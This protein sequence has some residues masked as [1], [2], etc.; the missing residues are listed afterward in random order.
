[1]LIMYNLTTL[2]VIKKLKTSTTGLSLSEAN[3][4]L[5]KYGQN[6]LPQSSEKITKLGIFFDQWK[7]PLIIILV[8]AGVI[9]GFLGEYVDMTVISITVGVNIIIGFFQEY[10]ANEALKKLGKMIEY[11]AIVVRDGRQVQVAGVDIVP[12]DI[13]VLDAG[14]NIQAD[15]RIIEEVGLQV[16]ESV[17]TGESEPVKKQAKILKGEKSIG[18]RINMLFKG[19]SI[20]NGRARAVVVATG[21]DTEIGKIASLVKETKEDKTPL[22]KQL[23]SLGKKIGVV[24]LFISIAIF[25][26]GVFSKSEHHSL[27]EMF[28]TAVAVAVAAIPEGLVI[29]MTVILAIGMQH[30]LKRKA[31]VRK[32][33]A[34]ETLGSV[35]VI[36]TDKTGT[37]TEGKMRITRLVT[38]GDD[39]N[40]EELKLVNLKETDRHKN[41][42]LGLRIGIMCNDS[43]LTNPETNEKDWLFVGDTTDI[44]FVY[45]GMKIGLEKHT[46]DKVLTRVDEL[47]F[48]STNKFM[49][50]MHKI[51][52]E[53]LIYV[54]G[55]AEMLY[56]RCKFFEED[57]VVKKL[58]KEKLAWFKDQEEQMTMQGLRVLGLAYKKDN[59][60][61]KKI[62]KDKLNDLVLVGLVALS[63]PLRLDVKETINK[64]RLAG[65]RTV[66]ITGDHVRTAQSIAKELGIPAEDSQ[67]FDGQQ[68]EK[69]SSEELKEV[70]RNVY[71]FARVDPKHKIRIVQAFQANGEIVAMT[72]DGINDAPA[73][74]GADIGVA[75][76]SG[77]TVAKEISDMV[78]LDD[79]YNTIVSAV[80]EGRGIYQNI[81]KVIVYLLAGSFSEVFLIAGS[82]IAGLPLALLPAQILWMNLVQEGVV[83]MALGFDAGDKENMLDKPRSNNESII[84]RE[85]KIIILIISIIPNIVLFGIFL[86]YMKTTGDIALVRTLMFIG[87]GIDALF[88][89]FSI[90]SMKKMVWQ[91]SLNKNY[92]LIYALVFSWIML[93]TAIY[94]KPLQILLRT[95]PLS[96]EQWGLMLSFGLLNLMLIEIIKAIFLIKNR[97]HI[98]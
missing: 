8:I 52:H 94:F 63:D 3:L 36:C 15:A 31:L 29:S 73:L 22:Q 46:L 4:R 62:Q 17:L 5:K 25:A 21:K 12:G 1:M 10:K 72:G 89:I 77:T 2:E 57:G 14:E 38:A 58:T 27:L 34:A 20:V 7:S 42:I 40:F 26:L 49:A 70:V 35:S 60:Q 96:I 61:T 16:N 82:I 67:V 24:V 98:T 55:A 65:I 11:K 33:L 13:L 68:L 51:D 41:A 18:D 59:N 64:T 78:L 56:K 9:S 97:K 95:V 43:L 74:K 6:K 79:N 39:L 32:L 90:R 45:A 88:Y 48:D 83:V 66:M 75:L 93:V 86:Y 30:I 76:G 37:L 85:M 92:Y 80:E 53:S 19:T 84:D 54:K 44:A 69:L 50:T 47:P 87:I 81:K 71:V 91:I 28:E 23:S